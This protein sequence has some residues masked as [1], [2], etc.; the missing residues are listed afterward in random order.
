MNDYKMM[1]TDTY[2]KK[3]KVFVVTLQ[4][5]KTLYYWS[6]LDQIEWSKP[7]EL[8]YFINKTFPIAISKFPPTLS[9]S[10]EKELT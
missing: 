2:K 7:D 4:S 6:T 10:T 9:A 1:H 3:F 5:C 8:L